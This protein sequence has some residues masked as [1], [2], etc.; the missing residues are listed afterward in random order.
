LGGRL[1]TIQA[2]V[3]LAK[4]PHYPTEIKGRQAVAGKYTQ[5]LQDRV[6]TPQVKTD[7]TSVWAQY[8]VQ[9]ENR[10]QVQESLKQA[11][12]PTAVHYP[13]PLSHLRKSFSRSHECSNE[14]VSNG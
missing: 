9:V 2:A 1:D 3:L 14:S 13:M 6:T 4:L 10:D 8:T 11:G 5:S 12:I 7:R